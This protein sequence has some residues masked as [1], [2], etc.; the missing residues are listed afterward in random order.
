MQR[1]DVYLP[2]QY[3]IHLGCWVSNSVS[4]FLIP[5]FCIVF[6]MF[7]NSCVSLFSCS[8]HPTTD[9]SGMYFQYDFST[10]PSFSCSNLFSTEP[11]VAFTWTFP[12][13]LIS[14]LVENESDPTWRN[15]LLLFK[16]CISNFKLQIEHS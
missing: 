14:L 3:N 9:G 8:I 7:F 1:N 2:I 13:H 15:Y 11:C 10:I 4:T 16:S 12:S 6:I 5:L